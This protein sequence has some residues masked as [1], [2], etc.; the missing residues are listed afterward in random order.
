MHAYSWRRVGRWTD[1]VFSQFL[2]RLEAFESWFSTQE[3]HEFIASSLLFL[4][5]GE[6]SVHDE[7]GP[8]IRLIDFA[9]VQ[10][11]SRRDDGVLLG[12][13]TIQRCFRELLTQLASQ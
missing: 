4:Y 2:A 7:R 6:A 13:R 3:E 10:A 9:H 5:D 11:A 8:D 12:I 1:A